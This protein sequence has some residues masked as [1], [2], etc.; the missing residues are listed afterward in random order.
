M[1]DDD[2]LIFA[3]EEPDTAALDRPHAVQPK[4]KIIIIDDDPGMHDV[5]KLTLA[6]F[7]FAGHGGVRDRVARPGGA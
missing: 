6:D 1:I 2:A 5:T 4:W 7:E 3:A